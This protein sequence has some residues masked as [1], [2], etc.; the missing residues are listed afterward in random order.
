MQ[1]ATHGASEQEHDFDFDPV[2]ERFF[3]RPPEPC[4]IVH[5]DWQPEPLSPLERVAMLTT[6]APAMA[7][8]AVAVTWLLSDPLLAASAKHA[9]GESALPTLESIAPE[10]IEAHVPEP[11][12]LA[13]PPVLAVLAA[14]EAPTA[15]A[16]AQPIA[17]LAQPMKAARRAG[18]RRTKSSS[19]AKRARQLLDAG[20]A[21]GARD[22]ARE[23]VRS[24]P[25]RAAGYIVLAAALD[26]LGDRAGKAA[27]FRSCAQLATDPLASACKSLARARWSPPNERL[28]PWLRARSC[29]CPPW[30]PAAGAPRPARRPCAARSARDSPCPGSPPARGAPPSH[31]RARWRAR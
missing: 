16:V 31:R 26:K 9:A 5:D 24:T 25:D 1:D 11:L 15:H 21:A 23:A 28:G 17:H 10:M 27:T 29:A 7:M 8:L 4:E 18:P 6:V 19:P 2:A 20:N 14:P 22:L 3:S 12:P 30:L 13:A